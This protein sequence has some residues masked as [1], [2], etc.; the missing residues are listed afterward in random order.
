MRYCTRVFALR[1]S[2]AGEE[3][4]ESCGHLIFHSKIYQKIHRLKQ[5]ETALDRKIRA[6]FPRLNPI[7]D[8]YRSEKSI[9]LMYYAIHKS[10]AYL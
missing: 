2:E 8:Y 1:R 7:M 9:S 4:C 6:N 5:L 10:S 3:K